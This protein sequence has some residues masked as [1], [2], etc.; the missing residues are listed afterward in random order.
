MNNL[1]LY[2]LKPRD[3]LTGS[4]GTLKY[5]LTVLEGCL[6]FFSLSKYVSLTQFE[7]FCCFNTDLSNV[8]IANSL[9]T[10]NQTSKPRVCFKCGQQ[11]EN[12]QCTVDKPKCV[13]CKG[14][15]PIL[16]NLPKMSAKNKTILFVFSVS[17]GIVTL[18]TLTLG[19]LAG[20]NKYL[21]LNLM[22][23]IY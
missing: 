10:C 18:F 22:S 6:S 21:T 1:V 15:H 23:K 7:T 12:K 2:I 19:L 16:G 5:N 20:F 17:E 13:N 11:H 4:S 3:I 9:V 8:L 14:E